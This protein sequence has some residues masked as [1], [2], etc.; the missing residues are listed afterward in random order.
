MIDPFQN[1]SESLSFGDL[2]FENR[3]DRVT[4]YGNIDITRDK[5]GLEQ[6]RQLKEILDLIVRTLE[7]EPCLPDQ[8]A[9]PI[10]TETIEN[11]FA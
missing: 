9:P 1:E 8:I 2:T 3:T 4:V 10:K 6:A 7:K 11:P 5:V